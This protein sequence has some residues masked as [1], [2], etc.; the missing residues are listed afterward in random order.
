M[1]ISV[2]GISSDARRVSEYESILVSVRMI[3]LSSFVEV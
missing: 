3:E 1:E 2:Y